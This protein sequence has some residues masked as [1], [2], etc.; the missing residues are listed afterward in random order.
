M[1][2]SSGTISRQSKGGSTDINGIYYSK[3]VV[4]MYNGNGY[5]TYYANQSPYAT[6]NTGITAYLNN[7]SLNAYNLNDN[8][9]KYGSAF[10]SITTDSEPDLISA[11]GIDGKFG[12]IKKNDLYKGKA[13]N[14]EEALSKDKVD[15]NTSIPVYESDGVTIID[16]FILGT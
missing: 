9:E 15:S 14:L 2:N 6:F 7:N 3:G 16:Y 4:E 5:N 13:S 12:Y 10:Y 1:Y 11:Q 8:G